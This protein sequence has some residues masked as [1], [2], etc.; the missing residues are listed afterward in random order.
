MF[1]FGLETSTHVAQAG[2]KI[3]VWTRMTLNSRFSWLYLQRVETIGTNTPTWDF[4]FNP[5]FSW[6]KL[7]TTDYQCV[8]VLFWKLIYL[9][10][11]IS[12]SMLYLIHTCTVWVMIPICVCFGAHYLILQSQFLHS[13]WEDYCSHSPHPLVAHCSLPK[14]EDFWTFP[15]P[16]CISICVFLVQSCMGSYIGET[17]GTWCFWAL[18]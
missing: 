10:I 11:Y 13:S 8:F 1:C 18:Q 14:V 17:L 9:S 5:Q 15:L 3:T 12:I 6:P 16:F 7:L 4:N 2:L